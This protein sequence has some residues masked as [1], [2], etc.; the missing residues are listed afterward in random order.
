MFRDVE[1][2]VKLLASALI[3]AVV[4]ICLTKKTIFVTWK[5]YCLLA[6]IGQYH[7]EV[8]ILFWN[9]NVRFLVRKFPSQFKGYWQWL[10]LLVWLFISQESF[11]E[12][13]KGVLVSSDTRDRTV[14]KFRSC[15]QSN[16]WDTFSSH[17][18]YGPLH[19]THL[20]ISYSKLNSHSLQHARRIWYLRNCID[21]SAPPALER[22]LRYKRSFCAH[23]L[24]KYDWMRLRDQ[25]YHDLASLCPAIHWNFFQ[26]V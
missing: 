6:V 18:P 1:Q 22:A 19:V 4:S 2:K 17:S 10:I 25:H 26:R 14:P 5:W 9:V 3:K 12:A 16:F 20:A 15:F 11:S 7:C 8:F 24:L 13:G 23:Q 21:S